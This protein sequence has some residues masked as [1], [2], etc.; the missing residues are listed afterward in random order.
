ML[1]CLA[2]M[3]FV[4]NTPAKHPRISEAEKNYIE[5]SLAVKEQVRITLNHW[6]CFLLLLLLFGLC[7]RTMIQGRIQDFH[8]RGGGG[9]GKKVMCQHTHI[10]SAEPNSLSAGVQGPLKGPGS[11]AGVVLMLSSCYLHAWALFLSILMKN[12]IKE[13]IVDPILRGPARLLLPPPPPP[14]GSATAI[15]PYNI[16]MPPPS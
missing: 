12:W 1:W 13:N 4:Y 14:T 3:F 11:S 8:L 16:H 2:W 15:L 7:Q 6:H 9:G 10:T 5:T